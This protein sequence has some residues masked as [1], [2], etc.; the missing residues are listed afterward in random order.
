VI[1]TLTYLDKDQYYIK[2]KEQ[3]YS[4]FAVTFLPSLLVVNSRED[5]LRAIRDGVSFKHEDF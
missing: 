5:F 4:P 3:L 2:C 1:K